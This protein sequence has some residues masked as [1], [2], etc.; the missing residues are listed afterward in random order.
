MFLQ[1]TVILLFQLSIIRELARSFAHSLIMYS[2]TCIKR[3]RLGQWSLNRGGLLIEVIKPQL[4]HDQ[5][6]LV[7]SEYRAGFTVH[8]T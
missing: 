5:V 6:V 3:P 4:G 8:S 1:P 2:A 7:V